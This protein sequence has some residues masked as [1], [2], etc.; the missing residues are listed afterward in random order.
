MSG[1]ERSG[2]PSAR[3]RPCRAITGMTAVLLP[4]DPDGAVDWAAFDSLVGR[5]V[6]AGLVPAVNMD[7]GFGPALS[8]GERAQVL[9]R[10]TALCAA[11]THPSGLGFV[12]GAHVVDEPGA[13]A[14][15]D[16][17]RREFDAISAAG[18]T[19][20][21]FPS[22]GLATLDESAWVDAHR[23]L[24]AGVDRFLGFELGT[25]FHP[26]GRIASL[27]AFT[28]L[29]G[30]P[31]LIGAK[32]SSLRRAPEWDRLAVRDRVRPDFM[33]LTGNDR[34]IDMVTYGS[35]YLLGL[36]AFAPDAFARRDAAWA[37]GDEVTFWEL[38]DLLAYLGQFAFRAPVPGY[39]H[40]AAMFL[41]RRGWIG[42][43]RTHS[44]SP[45]RPDSDGAVL[46]ELLERLDLL[47]A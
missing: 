23:R 26:A 21:V 43:E 34:A 20:I 3:L 18:G 40:D 32:H 31:E 7:T 27:E 5:T 24:A 36:A 14:D 6:A 17:Y 8:A 13:A 19:P 16:A 2:A 12:A 33:V 47:L 37:T 25:M 45:R 1:P 9:A 38:N 28:E 39:R 46:D 44:G 30:I 4:F 29:L 15:L 22:H 11:A 10:T 41:F 42:S 35:D